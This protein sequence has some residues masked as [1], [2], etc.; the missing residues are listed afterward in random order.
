[1]FKRLVRLPRDDKP[2]LDIHSLGRAAL[3][4]LADSVA[5]K[6]TKLRA[7]FGGFLKSW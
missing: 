5:C 3:R 4:A 2:I 1:M 6:L 7:Q